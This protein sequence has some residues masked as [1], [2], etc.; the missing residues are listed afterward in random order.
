MN[1]DAIRQ[2]AYSLAQVPQDQ[3]QKLTMIRGL[4]RAV[5]WEHIDPPGLWEQFTEWLSDTVETAVDVVQEAF[6]T[7][8]N[9]L[10]SVANAVMNVINGIASRV[11]TAIA[12][13]LETVFS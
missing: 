3:I 8:V 6:N 13:G 4:M 10:S 5:P 2:Q 7:M 12:T 9:T 11:I 1:N